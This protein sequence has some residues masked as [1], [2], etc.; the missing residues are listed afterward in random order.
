VTLQPDRAQEAV[1]AANKLGVPVPH[2]LSLFDDEDDHYAGMS[3]AELEAEA[4]RLLEMRARVLRVIRAKKGGYATRGKRRE[5]RVGDDEIV[6]VYLKYRGL[7]DQ[8]DYGALKATWTELRLSERHVS[9]RLREN[10]DKICAAV[11][12]R[13]G[14]V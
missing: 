8:P 3:L 14:G 7:N 10:F 6:E 12:R 5:R 13:R 1:V 11:I 4:D 9:R 2:T